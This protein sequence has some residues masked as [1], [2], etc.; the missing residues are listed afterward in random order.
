LSVLF[1]YIKDKS[2]QKNLD[3]Y[4]LVQIVWVTVNCRWPFPCSRRSHLPC[5]RHWLFPPVAC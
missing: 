2:T 4:R 1:Q 3:F 5:L